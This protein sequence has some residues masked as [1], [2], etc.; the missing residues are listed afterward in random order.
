MPLKDNFDLLDTDD[1]VTHE[2]GLDSVH[3][4]DP[5]YFLNSFSEDGRYSH[6]ESQWDSIRNDVLGPLSEK[7]FLDFQARLK[8]FQSGVK[9]KPKKDSN[10]DVVIDATEAELVDLRRKIY[11]TIMSSLDYQECAHKIMLLKTR[12]GLES[13]VC[14][15]VIECCM[16][17]RTYVKMYGRLGERLC[18]VKEVYSEQFAACFQEQ[19]ATCHRLETNRLRNVVN[20]FSSLLGSD[21][22]SWRVLSCIYLTE[23]ST[24]SSS[25]I[26]VKILFQDLASSLGITELMRRLATPSYREAFKGLFPEEDPLHLRFSINFFTA[27]QLGILTEGMRTTLKNL[28]KIATYCSSVN[29]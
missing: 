29:E 4:F 23:Q 9:D 20:F 12:R 16:Q 17:E 27:I 1:I 24:T 8:R 6:H 7:A 3:T 15:M 28:P 25:R 10:E 19:Y 18:K 14:N 5:Q 22:I 11:L 26:F 13:E 21:S 2:I